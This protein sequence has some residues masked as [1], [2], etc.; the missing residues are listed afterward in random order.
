MQIAANRA[1]IAVSRV[2]RVAE[3]HP[4]AMLFLLS[5]HASPDRPPPHLGNRTSGGI[6]ETP[7]HQVTP[8]PLVTLINRHIYYHSGNNQA[9]ERPG[10]SHAFE[11]RKLCE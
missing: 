8:C 11:A 9:T 4:L 3:G 10:A 6:W 7:G 5:G 2:V 1:N